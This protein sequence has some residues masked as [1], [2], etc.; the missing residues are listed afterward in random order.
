MAFR[1]D[2]CQAIRLQTLHDLGVKPIASCKA[3]NQNDSL[4]NIGRK[5]LA[6]RIISYCG[7]PVSF[8]ALCAHR[9]DDAGDGRFKEIC[10]LGPERKINQA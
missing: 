3:S 7:F 8:L 9:L 6:K 10:H 1:S 2:D 5:F 4:T